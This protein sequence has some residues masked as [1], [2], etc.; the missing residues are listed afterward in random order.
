[1]SDIVNQD[2]VVL[3]DLKDGN[4]NLVLKEGSV[5][6]CVGKIDLPDGTTVVSLYAGKG[7]TVVTSFDLV[8]LYEP[9]EPVAE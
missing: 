9:A 4:D 6:K 5:V 1:M 8:A 7:H 2:V 3:G